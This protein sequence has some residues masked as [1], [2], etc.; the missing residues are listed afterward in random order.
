MNRELFRKKLWVNNYGACC[1]CGSYN[2][3]INTS[4]G[5]CRTCRR[6]V[7]MIYKDSDITDLYE[8][9]PF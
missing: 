5:W 7:Q 4:R 2:L 1:Y 9:N 3:E 8:Y 6:I